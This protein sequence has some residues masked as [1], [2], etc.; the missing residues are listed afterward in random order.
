ME[1]IKT[2]ILGLPAITALHL[3]RRVDTTEINTPA[4]HTETPADSPKQFPSIFQGLGNMGEEYEIC[5][6]PG[7]APQCLFAPRHVPLPLRS[8][9]KEELD[10]MES[11]GVISKVDKPTP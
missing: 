8:K 3:A 4:G 1:G 10:C 2:K 11:I 5:L 9:V 6:K 7:A